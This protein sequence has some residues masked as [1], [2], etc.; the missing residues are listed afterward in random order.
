MLSTVRMFTAEAKQL[1]L[2]IDTHRMVFYVFALS[3]EVTHHS[4]MNLSMSRLR[5][6]VSVQNVAKG[7]DEVSIQASTLTQDRG[8]MS[9]F[10]E[11]SYVITSEIAQMNLNLGMWIG[12][13]WL[14]KEVDCKNN[15]TFQISVQRITVATPNTN[16]KPCFLMNRSSE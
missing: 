14:L 9:N 13:H 2:Y 6:N 10:I 4:N 12:H 7:R 16:L 3:K 15:W 1:K 8:G 11:G 5:K